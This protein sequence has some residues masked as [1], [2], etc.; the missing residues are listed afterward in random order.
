LTN[1]KQIL[2]VREDLKMPIGKTGAQTA[3]AAMLFILHHLAHNKAFSQAQLDWMFYE[4]INI[5]D[6]E[7]GGMKKIVLGVQDLNELYSVVEFAQQMGIE[8]HLVHDEGLN[9]I[10]CAALGPSLS[11]DLDQITSHLN[12]LG[13]RPSSINKAN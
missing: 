8:T 13:S 2:L 3:H 6:W 4:K 7:W 10:T 11:K 12:L 5:P 9:T 1:T